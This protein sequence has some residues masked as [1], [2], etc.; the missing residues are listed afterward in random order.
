[1]HVVSKRDLNSAELETM[2]ISRNPT[3]VMM[4]NGEVQTRDEATVYVKEMDLFVTVVL[5]EETFF[6]SGSSARIMG[7]LTTGPAV[8]N[9]KNTSHQRL[10]EHQLQYSELQGL[11][12]K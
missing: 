9:K 3:T 4:A 1:M 11:P 10:Q 8:K 6:H 2:R 5:L 12:P 7:F